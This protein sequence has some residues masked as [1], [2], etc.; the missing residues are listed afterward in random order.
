[1][2]S[3]VVS[4]PKA[5]FKIQTE[6]PA[7]NRFQDQLQS[8]LNAFMRSVSEQLG[9]VP[10]FNSASRP[11]A[12]ATTAGVLIRV[13]EPNRPEEVQICISTSN[14]GHEWITIGL[15]SS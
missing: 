2:P 11:T 5:L 3:P 4:L 6:D 8:V 7:F 1:M 15:A 14:G 10:Q 13:K 9:V 12:N